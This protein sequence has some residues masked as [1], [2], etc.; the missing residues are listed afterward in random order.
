[1]SADP[2]TNSI[3][4][5]SSQRDYAALRSVVDRLDQARRQVFI[6]AVIMDLQ[7][8]RSD[9]L[10]AT[11][12][13]G[14]T[15]SAAGQSGGWSTAATTRSTPSACCR[16]T[17]RRLQGGGPRHPRAGHPRERQPPGDRDQHPRV[18]YVL[19]DAMASTGDTDLLS[20][21]HILATDNIPAEISVGDNVPTQTNTGAGGGLGAL[22]GLAGG[23]S[24]RR[25]QLARW[26]RSRRFHRAA[27]GRR[28]Q[29][30]DQAA[31]QRLQ[32]GPPRAVRGDQR[33]RRDAPRRARCRADRQAHRDDARS[34]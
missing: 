22:A 3:V 24:G 33:G 18:R 6:E 13:L 26:P 16:A 19:I 34:S 8:K 15:F 4:V 14:D 11:F 29:D 32:R 31:P 7:L 5:T 17:P 20:T 2:A 25:Q 23:A 1:M 10:G 30:Q 12:H 27:R 9:T 28:Y 21:P